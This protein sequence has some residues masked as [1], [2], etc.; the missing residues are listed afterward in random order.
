[1]STPH[2]LRGQ[3]PVA[4]KAMEGSLYLGSYLANIIALLL[5]N[6]WKEDIGGPLSSLNYRK[7]GKHRKR[8]NIL[9]KGKD[10]KKK[11]GT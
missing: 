4:G 10:G 5:R 1:M 8:E 3:N 2:N 7:N 9:N 11:G 6:K